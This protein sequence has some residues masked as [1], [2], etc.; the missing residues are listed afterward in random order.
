MILLRAL[1]LLMVMSGQSAWAQH[2]DAAGAGERP[3]THQFDLADL[4]SGFVALHQA[5]SLAESY[6]KEHL[7]VDGHYHAGT[8]KDSGW[9]R[10]RFK[11]YPQGRSQPDGA[12]E[13]DTWIKSQDGSWAFQ[14]RLNEGS[15]TVPDLDQYL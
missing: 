14:F 12:I 7:D 6:V 11:F 5:L 4:A 3:E 8:E 9:G 10:M 2:P 13:A 1:M 15:P